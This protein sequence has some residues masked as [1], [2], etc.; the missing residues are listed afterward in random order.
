MKC[1]A[2]EKRR[3]R[4]RGRGRVYGN[5][6]ERIMIFLGFPLDFLFLFLF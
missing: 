6:A 1:K 4:R 5:D 2:R 3:I